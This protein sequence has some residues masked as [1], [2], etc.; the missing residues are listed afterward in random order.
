M[1]FDIKAFV[2]GVIVGLIIMVVRNLFVRTSYFDSMAFQGKN[3]EE[4]GKYYQQLIDD[5]AKN[6]EER[7][8]KAIQEGRPQ[9]A[10]K[11]ALEAQKYQ[12]D[13]S[14]AYNTYVMELVP[15]NAPVP[16]PSKEG[17]PPSV[18]TTTPVMMPQA[19]AP[20][21][22]PEMPQAPAPGPA[23][24]MMMPQVSMYEPE[25]YTSY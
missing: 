9:D 4:A 13:L 15:A 25:P 14:L 8:N 16:P 3:V 5:S 11:L 12:Q 6:F 23:P 2:V 22:A 7:S 20:G 18:Q 24:E 10:K 19:P 17:A 21:P 1:A